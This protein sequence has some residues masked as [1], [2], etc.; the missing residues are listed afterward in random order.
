VITADLHCHTIYSKDSLCQINRLLARCRQAGIQRIAI[1]DHNTI[2]G[3]L[4]A[5]AM[6]PEIVV[7]GE[8]IMTLKGELLAYY[9][10]EE[11]PPGLTPKEAIQRLRQQG[12]VI[13]VSHPFDHARHGAWQE[14]DLLEIAPLVD[15]LETMNA[16]CLRQL[17]NQE[18][19]EFAARVNLPGTAGSDAHLV[20]EAGTAFLL[21][22]DFTNAEEL[23]LAL[24]DAQ[25]KGKLSTPWVH[26]GSIFARFYKKLA[27]NHHF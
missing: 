20:S 12:A 15:A 22:P 17:Y 8:E 19:Q 2:R 25:L 3:A 27:I 11:V 18:A 16:R 9:L 10:Q 6:D 21:L 13:S 1:T 24:C 4:V 7:V 5:K 14:S 23:R 26:F